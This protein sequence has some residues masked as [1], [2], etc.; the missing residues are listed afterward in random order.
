MKLTGAPDMSTST[1]TNAA[2]PREERWREEAAFFDRA[3]RQIGTIDLPIDP[4]ALQRYAG[5]VLRSRF[6]KEYRFKVLGSLKGK[7]LLDVGCGDG[8]NSVMLARMGAQVTGIDVSP[9]AIEVARRRA[10]FNGVSNQVRFLC[11][12]V[13]KAALPDRTFDVVWG[14]GILH[15]VLDDLELVLSHLA[16]C[17]KP[18][19][20]LIF[21]E[22]I[23]L[24]PT[25]RKIRRRIPIR[26]DA[27]PGE[28]PMLGTEL[29]LVRRYIPDGVMRPYSIL[30][31]LDRLILVHYNYERSP[32]VRRGI[33]NAIAVFDRLLASLP[34]VRRLAST[35]V[36]HG[37]PAPIDS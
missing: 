2:K 19:G 34:G 37:H 3:A 26:T 8:M 12:P 24:S 11:S 29:D 7:T 14:D 31:R 20:V 10:E 17:A 33:V 1:E 5:P 28:R 23:N 13:E 32:V 6:N 16:R 25:L 18:D 15:H 35:C 36:L 9:G 21:S 4:L 22:P 27:T 30:G